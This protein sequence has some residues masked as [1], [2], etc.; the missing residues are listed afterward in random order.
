MVLV[1]LHFLLEAWGGE[2]FVRGWWVLSY[3]D[4]HC[5]DIELFCINLESFFQAST[6][7]NAEKGRAG[8]MFVATSPG[9]KRASRYGNNVNTNHR[10]FCRGIDT[11]RKQEDNRQNRPGGGS[12]MKLKNVKYPWMSRIWLVASPSRRGLL[13]KL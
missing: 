1:L 12:D 4:S 7:L 2:S 9:D 8:I 11:P 13:P 3:I 6:S 5:I 10:A